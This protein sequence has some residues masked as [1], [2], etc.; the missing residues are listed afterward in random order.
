MQDKRLKNV[1][2][3]LFIFIAFLLFVGG[4]L[5]L[6][7]KRGMFQQTIKVT[8]VFSDIRGLRVG[9]NVR[10]TGIDVGAITNITILSDTAVLVTFSIDR[11]VVPFV[12]NDSRTTIGTE[13]LMG[14]TIVLLLP[15]SPD[16]ESIQPGDQLGSIEPVGFDD[17]IFEIQTSSAKIAK[18]ADNLIE[19]TEKINR[20][21]GIFGKLFTDSELT[22]E[23]DKTAR[24]IESLTR[25]LN[26]ISAKINA[27]EG[28]VGRILID[29]EFAGRL[30]STTRSIAVVTKNLEDLTT[31]IKR[32]EGM[33]GQIMTDTVS[34]EGL[35]KIGYDLERAVA[36]LAEVS[37]K[38]NDE[39]NALHKF[40]ADPAVADS[41][42][43]LLYNL[44]TGII[45]VTEA[46]EALKRSGL[47]RAFSKDEEKIRRKEARKQQRK[48]D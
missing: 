37:E 42:E 15:G 21:D 29:E 5:I 3:G 47:V 27:G 25:N 7:R 41:V 9:S 32:G 16:S 40:I 10:F 8:T 1:R 30:D 24:S 36:N 45:E 35:N 19:I 11:N 22:E 28:L 18:V 46:S 48:A 4:I 12:K 44:N 43:V 20:G 17:I 38:L 23:I 6:G 14:S 31:G 39:N 34:Q 2:L 33:L 13:G 26:N